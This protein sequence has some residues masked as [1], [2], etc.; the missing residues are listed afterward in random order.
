VRSV[1]ARA[2]GQAIGAEELFKARRRALSIGDW[3]A[4]VS[5]IEWTLSG[6]V[7]PLWLRLATV[8]VKEPYYLHFLISQALCGLIAA[9]LS[10]FVVSFLSARAFY[11]ALVDPQDR[12]PEALARL[13]GLAQR[14]GVY[15]VLTVAAYFLSTFAVLWLA[16]STDDQIAIGVLG[17]I[18]FPTFILAYWLSSAIRR[19]LETLAIVAL[20]PHDGPGF[21]S[22]LSDSSWSISR[23]RS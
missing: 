8:P 4:W 14:T 23:L 19:D 5:A 7:F 12:D 3:V 6:V 20:P 22:E 21:S 13:R 11:P 16:N 2:F 9:S 15:F 17:V 10:F 18:G 1:R